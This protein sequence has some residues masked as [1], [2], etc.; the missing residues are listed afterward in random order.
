MIS[1][2]ISREILPH[3][4][5]S[6]L[7]ITPLRLY[8]VTSVIFH[9]LQVEFRINLLNPFHKS[10]IMP[11]LSLSSWTLSFLY[12]STIV[13]RKDLHFF[14]YCLF[15]ILFQY[16]SSNQSSSLWEILTWKI[17]LL[18]FHSLNLSIN[19]KLH[20]FIIILQR[21]EFFSSQYNKTESIIIHNI[22]LF[23]TFH[24][25]YKMYKSIEEVRSE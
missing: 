19:Y 25:A 7:S 18:I 12:L 3:N 17:R 14:F 21:Q 20:T 1:V 6:E 4:K 22:S 23:G 2:L 9:I 15:F 10:I 24:L 16:I 8:V 5:D 13:T 11:I